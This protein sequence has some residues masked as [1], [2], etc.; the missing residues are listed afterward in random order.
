MPYMVEIIIIFFFLP[1]TYRYEN[2]LKKAKNQ[3]KNEQLY[4]IN[5]KKQ[6]SS[7]QVFQPFTTLFK[8]PACSPPAGKSAGR[9]L[10]YF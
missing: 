6:Y 5:Q 9:H 3:L 8:P 2:M 4:C 7:R 10:N 1:N